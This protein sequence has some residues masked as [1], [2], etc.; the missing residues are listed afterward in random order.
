M[1]KQIMFEG[2][3]H[4]FPD[5]AT[6]E[7]MNALLPGYNPEPS[8]LNKIGNEVSG[9][10]HMSLGRSLKNLGQG[11]VDL[12]EFASNPPG[13]AMKY[14]AGKDIPYISEFAKHWPQYPESDIF[15]LGE[16]QPGDTL[17]QA[18]TPT[19]TALKGAQL[20]SKA[21]E[22]I[23]KKA[24]SV[25]SKA[26][27]KAGDILPVLK[28][29]K[30]KPYKKQMNILEEKNLLTGYK[31]NTF[32]VFEASNILKSKGM[33]IPHAAVD[34]AVAQTLEGNFKPW[35]DL[36]SSVKSEGRRLS[37]MGGVHRTLGEKLYKL[38]EKMHTE[39]GEAQINRGA[40]E[41]AELMH[42]GKARTARYHKISPASKIA[43]AAMAAALAPK[44]IAQMI[45]AFRK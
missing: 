45:K 29:I 5:D 9:A 41:A 11:A 7:E 20:S 31:P 32:D 6:E 3:I 22:Q 28:Y 2:K 30:N 18:A 39:I 4:S 34:E 8:L 40:P 19:G 10:A 36:Q 13:P 16:K 37:K 15:G 35:F 33:K 14:L 43:E 12:A 27:N 42:Q 38:G 25:P 26:A 23:V 44:W 21:L 24:L 17:F 1:T